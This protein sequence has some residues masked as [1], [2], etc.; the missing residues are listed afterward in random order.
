MNVN[1]KDEMGIFQYVH[2]EPK[3]Q[4]GKKTINNWN[5]YSG[6]NEKVIL[7]SKKCYR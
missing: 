2:P 7:T 1:I 5:R 3:G 4:A 6:V